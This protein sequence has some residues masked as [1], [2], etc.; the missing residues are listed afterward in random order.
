MER[1][2]AEVS[3][4]EYHTNDKGLHGR[5]QKEPSVLLLE[6]STYNLL[7]SSPVQDAWKYSH[8]GSVI[9]NTGTCQHKPKPRDTNDNNCSGSFLILNNTAK[10]HLEK[11]KTGT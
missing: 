7:L 10:I 4:T 8:N 11:R 1:V 2:T 9:Y 6:H 5:D 3:L